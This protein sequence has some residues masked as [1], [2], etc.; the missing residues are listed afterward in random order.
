MEEFKEKITKKIVFNIFFFRQANLKKK[1]IS[2]V[3]HPSLSAS[4][5]YRIPSQ[6]DPIHI[7]P[8]LPN[9]AYPYCYTS[10]KQLLFMYFFPPKWED[11]YKQWWVLCAV[12]LIK[13]GFSL[14]KLCT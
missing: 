1:L 3:L 11:F 5:K 7:T 9:S 13:I 4:M 14:I 12:L 6:A 2:I 10:L 8:L